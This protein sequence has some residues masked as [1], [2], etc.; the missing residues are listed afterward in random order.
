MHVNSFSFDII[1]ISEIYKTHNDP[2]ISLEGYHNIISKCRDDGPRGGVGMFIKSTLNYKIREDISVFIPHICETLFIEMIN[3]S[4]RNIVVGVIYGP[5]TE[6]LADI[7][8]YS[9]NLEHIMDTIQR[10]N[11]QC[12]IMGDMNIDFETHLRTNEYLDSL[13]ANG[14]LPLISVV[15]KDIVSKTLLNHNYYK[16]IRNMSNVINVKCSECYAQ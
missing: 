12:M 13:F 1:G 8:T 6:P 16:V 15:T 9:S 3:D 2:R 11:K 10:E 5:N 4:V 14:F 7:D